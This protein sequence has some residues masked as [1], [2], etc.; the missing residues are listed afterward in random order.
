MSLAANAPQFDRSFDDIYRELLERIPRYNPQWTNY[1]EGDPGITLLQ[2]FAWLTE[3][4]L[5]RMNDVPRATYLKF[6]ELLA[7]ELTP[8]RPAGVHLV[9]TPKA[10]QVA[11]VIP[12]QSRYS[13][14]GGADTV[15]FETTQP[16]GVISAAPAALV[17][18]AGGTIVPLPLPALPTVV[19]FWPLG[20]SPATG[21]ALYFGFTPNPATTTPFPQAMSFLAV[22]PAALAAGQLQQVGSQDQDLVPPATL[23]WEYLD[24]PS[25]DLWQPLSTFRDDTV[26]LTHDGYIQIEGPQDIRPQVPPALQ[27]RFPAPLYW[28]RVRLDQ[29]AYPSGRAPQL[30]FLLPNAVEAVNLVTEAAYTLGTSDGQAGQAFTFPDSPVDPASLQI[31]VTP[32]GGTTD[33]GWTAI[34]DLLAAG[35]DDKNYFLN[36]TAGTVSF[37]DG[38]NGYIPSAGSEI[39]ATVWRHGGGK[40]G[41]SVAAGAVTTMVSQIA[42]IDSVINPRAAAGGADEESIDDFIQHAPDRLRSSDSRAVTAGDFERIAT[43]IDGI[44]MAKAIGGRHPDYPNVSVPGALTVF[45]VADS[46]ALPPVPSAEA[47]RGVC[48]ALDPA[49][50][51][52]T[53]VYVAPATFIE[54]RIEARIL[55][56]PTASLDQVRLD[57]L[58]RLN[59]YLNPLNRDF[60]ETISGAAIYACLFGANAERTIRSVDNLLIYVNNRQVDPGAAVPI[61]SDAVFFP[62]TH[63]I[64]VRPDMSSG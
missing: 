61:G 38:A 62:G 42:G 29:G 64:V 44:A 9:F 13:G 8:A 48:N 3:M 14:Q 55:V 51:L 17:V 28:I 31:A 6:A 56:T 59:A 63:L 36:S 53:E 34:D 19:P 2:L 50:L 40:A 57:A 35:P 39:V 15:I 22:Q 23:V 37:G 25:I 1:N 32:A 49:R 26:A 7:L 21:D 11:S 20:R 54:A 60:G 24:D 33:N 41:N 5:H 46:S 58:A 27:A 4:T 30:D 47:I 12:A 43:E 52:T 45:V 16:L 10:G 18:F